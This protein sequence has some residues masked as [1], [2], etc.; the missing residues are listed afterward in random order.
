MLLTSNKNDLSA[1]HVL[2]G[3][4]KHSHSNWPRQGFKDSNRVPL[5]TRLFKP[6]WSLKETQM[7]RHSQN[8]LQLLS[9]EAIILPCLMRLKASVL[10]GVPYRLQS[11]I[12]FDPFLKNWFLLTLTVA[13]I[14]TESFTPCAFAWRFLCASNMSQLDVLGQPTHLS[15]KTA[16]FAQGHHFLIPLDRMKRSPGGLVD[17]KVWNPM[18]KWN[19]TR[20]LRQLP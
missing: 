6:H 2:N 4:A 9:M 16:R 3:P 8:L 10:C 14:E 5:K 12:I 20:C 1:S 15:P 11:F 18:A 13:L 7:M 17:E 19:R